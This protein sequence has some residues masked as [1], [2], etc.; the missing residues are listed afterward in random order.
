M[1]KYVNKDTL[2][3]TLV[4]TLHLKNKRQ[5]HEAVNA[6]IEE[7]SSAL[8]SGGVIDIAYFG[9]FYI[10][11]RKSRMG[12]NPVTKEKMEIQATRLP[13]FKPSQ[14][15]KKRCNQSLEEDPAQSNEE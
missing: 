3:D 10:F 5:A 6:L 11:D 13:K 1:P 7:M 8:E 9:K 2:A 4:S 12:I 15:L 14:T